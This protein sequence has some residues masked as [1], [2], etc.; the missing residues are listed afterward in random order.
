MNNMQEQKQG[1]TEWQISSL[2]EGTGRF[3]LYKGLL[4]FIR[5]DQVDLAII[6][7][8]TVYL[9]QPLLSLEN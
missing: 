2:R 7:V 4:D 3:H 9:P 8:E 1:S 6:T 5:N